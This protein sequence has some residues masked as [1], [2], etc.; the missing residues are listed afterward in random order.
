MAVHAWLRQVEV[1]FA[2]YYYWRTVMRPAQ[3]ESRT[4]RASSDLSGSASSVSAALPHFEPK[5][6]LKHELL[7]NKN[8]EKTFSQKQVRL[9][10][11]NRQAM[12]PCKKIEV[13]QKVAQDLVDC[14]LLLA[15]TEKINGRKMTVWKRRTLVEVEGDENAE[16]ERKRLRVGKDCFP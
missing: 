3:A 14:G 15:T 6:M 16:K 4:G 9:A 7:T 10:I 11:R 13:I 12:E 2:Y 1:H 5:D 8:F